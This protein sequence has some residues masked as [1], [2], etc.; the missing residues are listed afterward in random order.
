MCPLW[1]S[2]GRT[3][4]GGAVFIFEPDEGVSRFRRDQDVQIAVA[5][6]V[7]QHQTPRPADRGLTREAESLTPSGR[8]DYPLDLLENRWR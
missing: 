1:W 4:A 3:E 7:L 8:F 5:V 6:D 2:H